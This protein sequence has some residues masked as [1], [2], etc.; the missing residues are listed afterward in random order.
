MT[1]RLEMPDN[2]AEARGLAVNIVAEAHR[3]V[4]DRA[5]TETVERAVLRMLGMQGASEQGIPWPE[6]LV[7]HLGPKIAGGAARPVL[8]AMLKAGA[9]SMDALVAA[10][11]AGKADL[12]GDAAPADELE[13]LA[14]ELRSHADAHLKKV[15][16]ERA[17][18]R[19]KL[20]KPTRPWIY[21]V[22]GG[23]PIDYRVQ[24]AQE[25][26]R[27]G[28]DVIAV[29]AG[30]DR[31]GAMRAGDVTVN[32]YRTLRAAF[33][34]VGEELGRY[35]SL[36]VNTR[37]LRMPEMAAIAAWEG[38]D[39]ILCDPWPGTLF[40]QF[41]SVRA[42]V[43]QYAARRCAARG[44]VTV[45]T[46]EDE[47]L[48]AVDPVAGAGLLMG[49]WLLSEAMCKKAGL[50][51][52]RVALS[53]TTAVDPELPD[54]LSYELANVLAMRAA[55]PE[56]PARVMPSP[57]SSGHPD[58]DQSRQA[59]MPLIAAVGGGGAPVM[60]GLPPDSPSFTQAIHQTQFAFDAAEDLAD[61]LAVADEGLI[62]K[63]P[64]VIMEETIEL[65]S[66][67][68]SAGLFEAV[69]QGVFADMGLPRHAGKGAEGV[70]QKAAD[71][72]DPTSSE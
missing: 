28:A 11:V 39:V 5:T 56:H 4:I 18:L 47:L 72:W 44:A 24:Q 15:S 57:R 48:Q 30:P 65:L 33:D 34:A 69:G 61:S 68:E 3:E 40:H 2:L 36:A 49:S 50:P 59:L 71:Y 55:F 19:K 21:A 20:R 63:R 42:F 35:V 45:S 17:E 32:D 7:R 70:V 58:A 53:Y 8:T 9:R 6:A 16:E 10:I 26:A 46:G 62:A 12:S 22:V 43:D 41:N 37:G 60:L 1:L 13:S 66:H 27:Q 31:G 38:V 64:I 23:G 29:L 67:V 54:S 51:A 52:E 14:A 25:A